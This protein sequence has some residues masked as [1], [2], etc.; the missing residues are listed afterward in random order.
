MN[1]YFVTLFFLFEFFEKR[2]RF[3]IGDRFSKQTTKCHQ[4]Y[5]NFCDS[6]D[7]SIN[8]NKKKTV[9]IFQCNSTKEKKRNNNTKCIYQWHM[10][11]L[12][13]IELRRCEE[14]GNIKSKRMKAN[15]FQ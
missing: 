12:N 14:N 8:K 4:S 1:V 2:K 15:E 3:R 9:E 10:V 13:T 11:E 7:N 5:L 6:C